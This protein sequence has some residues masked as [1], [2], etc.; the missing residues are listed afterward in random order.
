MFGGRINFGVMLYPQH[1]HNK[2]YAKA[3]IGGKKIILVF[4]LN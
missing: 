2:S 4:V 1:F 3:V